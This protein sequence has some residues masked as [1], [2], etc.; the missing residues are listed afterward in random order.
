MYK[1]KH[2]YPTWVDGGLEGAGY[3]RNDS[4]WFDMPIF[5]DWFISCYLPA[6]RH[7]DGPKVIIGDN[8]SSHLSLEVIKLCDANNVRF[9][10]LPPNATHLCQPLDVAIFRPIKRKW[11]KVLDTWKDK[12]FG[13]IPNGVSYVNPAS[14]ANALRYVQCG[15]QNKQTCGNMSAF[16]MYRRSRRTCV[17]SNSFVRTG[18]F[19]KQII[20][21]LSPHKAAFSAFAV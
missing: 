2:L 16:P 1:A 13:T 18:Q 12:H 5:E 11:R 19:E 7:L 15:D 10:L 17:R 8:L 21:F 20:L 6:I 14:A 3:N 4:G 9:V